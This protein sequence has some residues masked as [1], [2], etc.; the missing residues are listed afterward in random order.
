MNLLDSVQLSEAT[1]ELLGQIAWMTLWG[2]L[3]VVFGLIASLIVRY[4]VERLA[5]PMGAG[6]AALLA[7][8]LAWSVLGVVVLTVATRLGA[9]VAGFLG[10]IAGAA[11][12]AGVAL[13]F[14]SQTSAANV[15]S[16][17]FLLGE[18]PFEEG[19]VIEVDGQEGMVLS[20][21]LL[22][23]K[24]RTFD[25]RYVRVPNETV[26]KASIINVSR[27]PVRRMEVLI[28]VQ[29]G[30]DLE[31]VRAVVQRVA[32]AVNTILQDPEPNVLFVSVVD[33]L[34]E[35]KCVAWA[36]QDAFFPAK[37]TFSTKLVEALLQS[38]IPLLG[39]RTEVSVR[40]PNGAPVD[41]P[42]VA[43]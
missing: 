12:I 5:A 28:R 13:G 4:W 42:E 14:A 30:T 27:F 11:G 31:R 39:S 40:P 8:V 9:P 1:V 10:W 17:L 21:D 25:N 19:D 20:V 43:P 22:S 35:L 3:G 33:G 18:R 16:G 7:R 29:P 23:V 24:L 26:M 15:I 41:A 6:R 34:V 37:A 2:A 36:T 32:A 38:D